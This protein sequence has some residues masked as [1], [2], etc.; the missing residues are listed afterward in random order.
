MAQQEQTTSAA[1]ENEYLRRYVDELGGPFRWWTEPA[2]A[3]RFHQEMAAMRRRTDFVIEYAWAIPSDEALAAL[4]QH[5]P[6]VEVGAGGGYWAMLLRDRGV[7]VVAYDRRPDQQAAPYEER[8]IPRRLWTEVSIGDTAAAGEHP[9]RALFLCWPPYATPMARDAL[10]AYLA[11]GGRTLVYVGEG[12]GGCNADDAFFALLAKRMVEG[13][14]VAIPQWPGIH[15]YL[16]VYRVV[17]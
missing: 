5:G 4:A 14:T 9:D 8:L 3:A 11:A 7:D 12:E 16:T 13:E 1:G 6:I 15:D 17:P 2:D 10:E